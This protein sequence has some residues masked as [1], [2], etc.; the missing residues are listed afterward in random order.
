[1]QRLSGLQLPLKDSIMAKRYHSS[2]IS[3]TSGHC[4]LP[5][6]VI[7]KDYPKDDGYSGKAIKDLYMCVEEQAAKDRSDLQRLTSPKKI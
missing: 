7:E 6:N 4:H 5:T 3:E 1:L 2:M